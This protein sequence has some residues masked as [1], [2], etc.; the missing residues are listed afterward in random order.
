MADIVGLGIVESKNSAKSFLLRD[1]GVLSLL[2]SEI[3]L[4]AP[5]ILIFRHPQQPSL[6]L[7]VTLLFL[8]AVASLMARR[9][10]KSSRLPKILIHGITL[11]VLPAVAYGVLYFAVYRNN[12]EGN[13][14]LQIVRSFGELRNGI[15]IEISLVLLAL[16]AWSRG[17]RAAVRGMTD[18]MRTGSLIR[19]GLLSFLL[20]ML[21]LENSGEE[22]K[23]WLTIC[24]FMSLLSTVLSRTELISRSH[25]DF[26]LAVNPGWLGGILL[27]TLL[28]IL[29]GATAGL[30]LQTDAA[31]NLVESIKGVFAA[32]LRVL[33]LIIAP[34][35]YFAGLLI[36]FLLRWLGPYINAEN[37]ISTEDGMDSDMEGMPFGDAML[38]DEGTLSPELV[39]VL[40]IAGVLLVAVMV[41]WDL[42]RRS[43]KDCN[44]AAELD[45]DRT[46]HEPL[47]E[48]LQR[49]YDNL[50]SQLRAVSDLRGIRRMVVESSIRRMYAQLLRFG[51]RNNVERA[52]S[53]TPHEY[54]KRLIRRFPHLEDDFQRITDAY[55]EIRYGQFP[56]DPGAIQAVREAWQRIS[57]FRRLV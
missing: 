1:F 7:V 9:A 49:L 47:L 17:V 52:K 33:E 2:V 22:L 31:L 15:P 26:K 11:A 23:V 57:A 39:T 45:T 21:V 37:M 8:A 56:E 19:W 30:V 25:L 41:L 3:T 27:L 55:V 24:F 34:V 44:P 13:A 28:T 50:R 43:I 40:A 10:L 46:D 12:F 16:F 32:M 36:S 20:L 51:T 54:Q 5:W 38:G 18:L 4:I 35:I 53:E 48:G 14:I 6:L 42:R 29:L